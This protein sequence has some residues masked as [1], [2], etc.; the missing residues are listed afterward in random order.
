MVLWSF[1]CWSQQQKQKPVERAIKNA[2][3]SIE[4]TS[5]GVFKLM[6][7]ENLAVK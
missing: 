2:A 7:K 1:S 6:L 5:E 4:Y 3:D